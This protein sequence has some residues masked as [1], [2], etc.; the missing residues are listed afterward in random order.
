M[1]W[2]DSGDENGMRDSCLDMNDYRKGSQ[3]WM[4][5]RTRIMKHELTSDGLD[6]K[7]LKSLY[8]KMSEIGWLDQGRLWEIMSFLYCFFLWWMKN[9]ISLTQV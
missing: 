1:F 9:F 8:N 6:L 3:P 5:L 2:N 4:T 7:H